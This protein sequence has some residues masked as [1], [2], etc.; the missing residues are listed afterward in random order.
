M[1]HTSSLIPL[2]LELDGFPS[3]LRKVEQNKG[4]LDVM[5]YRSIA[6]SIQPS[7]Q[8]LPYLL[9][10]PL[11]SLPKNPRYDV[12]T[13]SHNKGSTIQLIGVGCP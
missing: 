11:L 4:H 6:R 8:L 3:D 5:L 12:W 10:P 1:L 2:E 9:S 7:F 13:V